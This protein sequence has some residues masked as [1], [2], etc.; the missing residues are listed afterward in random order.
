MKKILQLLLSSI[1]SFFEYAAM[2]LNLNQ[3][4]VHA[5][6]AKIKFGMMMTDA[7]GKLG[8]HVFS[9]NRAGAYTRTKVT[10]VNPQSSFQT[11]VRN[12]FAGFT[13]GFRA[14]TSAQILAWNSAVANFT[15]TDVFGDI[16]QPSGINLYNRLNLNLANAGQV[17]ISTPPLPTAV[18]P[19]VIT[20]VIADVSLN[21]VSIA[22][23]LAAVPAGHT[24]IIEATA[25]LSPGKSFVKSEYRKITTAAAAAAF[26]IAAGVA[27]VAK[28]GALVAGTKIFV[29]VKTVS[30]TTGLSSAYSAVDTIVIP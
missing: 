28:F 8:G 12:S 10:P 11:A 23:A 30:N 5:K 14:L 19:A 7:R 15:S 25:Q 3:P 9:K 13:A 26:P 1:I 2:P 27:Y 24:L 4:V 22:S 16:K 18:T 21:S 17:A 29:R 6:C 20:G